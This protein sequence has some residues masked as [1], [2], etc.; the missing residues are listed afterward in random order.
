VFKGLGLLD[1]PA[2]SAA[3]SVTIHTAPAVLRRLL[4]QERP[5]LMV[6]ETGAL[7]QVVDRDEALDLACMACLGAPRTLPTLAND[8]PASLGLLECRDHLVV[9]PLVGSVWLIRW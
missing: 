1:D 7:I 8:A 3:R 5:A 9:R 6:F 4:G 2:D